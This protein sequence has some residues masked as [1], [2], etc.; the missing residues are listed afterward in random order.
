[1]ATQSNQK[2]KVIVTGAT[3]MVGEGVLHECLLNNNVEQ[4]LIINRKPGGITHPKLKEIIHADFNDLSP[5]EE[6]LKNYD[7]CFF[8]AGVSSIGKK[9]NEFYTLTYTLTL[10]FAAALAKQN[11]SMTFCYISGRGTD[12]SEK[13]K[14]MWARV[15]GKTE[16]DLTKLPFK[17]VYNFRPGVLEPTKGL[18]NTLSAYK[19]FGWIMPLVKL[20][21]PNSSSTLSE[22]GKAMINSVTKGYEKQI[23]EVKDIL[24]LSKE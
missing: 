6:Q 10:N 11:P 23:L 4:V 15:K 19:Y 22:L 5:V 21:A 24:A 14:L 3:G 1:M 8:C 13:G 7:A 18:K 12:S 20:I 17:K 2:I 16:N 9:E